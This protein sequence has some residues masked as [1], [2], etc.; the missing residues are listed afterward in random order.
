MNHEDGKQN[1][2]PDKQ[3]INTKILVDGQINTKSTGQANIAPSLAGQTLATTLELAKLDIYTKS[4]NVLLQTKRIMDKPWSES[5]QGLAILRPEA[6]FPCI[7]LVVSQSATTLAA[8]TSTY[9]Q[10]SA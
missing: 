2:C 5:I 3:V 10:L 6:Y 9:K 4:Y 8:H 7:R 1:D